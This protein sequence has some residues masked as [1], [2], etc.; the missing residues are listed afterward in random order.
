MSPRRL[1]FTAA[2]VLM[3][4]YLIAEHRSPVV[5]LAAVL[6]LAGHLS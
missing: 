3:L 6:R 5:I 1:L 4:G 2:A